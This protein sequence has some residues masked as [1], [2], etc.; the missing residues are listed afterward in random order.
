MTGPL[1]DGERLFAINPESRQALAG[2][3]TAALRAGNYKAAAIW[4]GRLVKVDPDCFAA[5]F[6]LR[7]ALQKLARPGS[8]DE[9]E[10]VWEVTRQLA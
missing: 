6:N 8:A 10:E 9:L 1:P 7:H 3:A 4:C 5:W 2:L